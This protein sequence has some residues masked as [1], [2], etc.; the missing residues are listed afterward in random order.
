MSDLVERLRDPMTFSWNMRKEAADRIEELEAAQDH[1]ELIERADDEVEYT[2]IDG[3]RFAVIPSDTYDAMRA[4][5][6]E[7][8]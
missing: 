6:G 7:S 2:N 1:S 8:V 3:L 4:A 5:L